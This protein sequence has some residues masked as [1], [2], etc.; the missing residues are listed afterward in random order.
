M[1]YV[2]LRPVLSAP[3]GEGSKFGG[4]PGPDGPFP[5][6]SAVFL[7]RFQC[8]TPYYAELH[9]IACSMADSFRPRRRG[10]P[11]A[12]NSVQEN[13]ACWKTMKGNEYPR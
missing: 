9:E 11:A 6:T 2:A 7:L 1:G 13:D 4:D 5:G 10:H 12:I 3:C 8:V